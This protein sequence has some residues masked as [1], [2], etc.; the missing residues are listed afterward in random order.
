[1]QHF[2]VTTTQQTRDGYAWFVFESEHRTL[3]EL[4]EAL[5]QDGSALGFRLKIRRSGDGSEIIGRES[6]VLGR[7]FVNSIVDCNWHLVEAT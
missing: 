3:A 2:I 4:H 6:Y 5:T 1:M 7:S